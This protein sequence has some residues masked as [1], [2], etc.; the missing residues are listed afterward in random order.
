MGTRVVEWNHLLL[1]NICY[2][3]ILQF[4]ALICQVFKQIEKGSGLSEGEYI[5][6][7]YYESIDV[8]CLFEY[9][10]DNRVIISQFN[11]QP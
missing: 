6:L 4:V 9:L 10:R 2:H 5:S 8:Q 7:G 3:I 1:L 11:R